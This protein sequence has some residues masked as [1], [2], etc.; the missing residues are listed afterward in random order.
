MLPS[1]LAPTLVLLNCSPF[2]LHISWFFAEDTPPPHYICSHLWAELGLPYSLVLPLLLWVMRPHHTASCLF[3]V[4]R[5]CPSLACKLL[6]NRFAWG[7]VS[8]AASSSS[9]FSIHLC[10]E[11][12]E[13]GLR[14]RDNSAR[15]KIHLMYPAELVH[16]SE[17]LHSKDHYC[18]SRCMG[19]C[20]LMILEAGCNTLSFLFL[21]PG[22][23]DVCHSN[24]CRMNQNNEKRMNW[25]CFH[26]PGYTTVFTPHERGERLLMSDA[27]CSRSQH[28]SPSR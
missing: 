3:S 1:F 17:C 28:G 19:H 2:Q 10:W 21:V 8:E 16:S 12:A 23:Q 27:S 7:R 25:Y 22:I 26:H 4:F 20:I 18:Y 15:N 5:L 9:S 14:Y 24:I 11:N 13:M 6:G